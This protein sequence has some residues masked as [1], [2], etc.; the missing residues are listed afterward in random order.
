MLAALHGLDPEPLHPILG[1]AD[2]ASFL[3]GQRATALERQRQVKLPDPWLSQIEGF[4][5]SAPTTTRSWL[6]RGSQRLT[7]PTMRCRP[8]T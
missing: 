1:P 8:V 4:L 3:T 6:M 5:E 2:W 7:S